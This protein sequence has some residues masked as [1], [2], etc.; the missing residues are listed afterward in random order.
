MLREDLP[1]FYDFL[2]QLTEDIA[3]SEIDKTLRKCKLH[4]M[5]RDYYEHYYCPQQRCRLLMI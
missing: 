3:L 4:N 1:K 5:S 2:R